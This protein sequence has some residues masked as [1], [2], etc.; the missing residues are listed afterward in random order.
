MK[1]SGLYKILCKTT[2]QFYIGI[3]NDIKN[4]FNSHKYQLRNR[5]HINKHLENLWY[6]YKEENFEFII[7]EQE[8]D[9]ETLKLKEF[10]Y[11]KNTDKNL[12]LNINLELSKKKTG[13]THSAI[14]KEK[15]SAFAKTRIGNKN[16][17]YGKTHS[18]TSINKIIKSKGDVSGKNN[19]F[20]GKYHSKETKLKLSIAHN[21]NKKQCSVYGIIYESAAAA[22]KQTNISYSSIKTKLRNINNK[23]CFYITNV[24]YK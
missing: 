22:A 1:I 19:P 2:G 15:I 8:N 18:Q 9:Y 20:Y 23:D 4:R 7:L 24:K 21:K 6:K 10:E 14:T 17:F 13:V 11:L 3:S 12:L 5:K 16:P